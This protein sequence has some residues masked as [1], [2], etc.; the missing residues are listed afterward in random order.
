MI[1]RLKV[2]FAYQRGFQV[3]DGSHVLETFDT[4]DEA[5]RY[6]DARDARV[7][8]QWA[9][10]VIGGQTMPCDFAASFGDDH[11]VGR[12]M[13]N[14]HGPGAGTWFWSMYSHDRGRVGGEH[15]I[16]ATKDQAVIGVERAYTRFIAAGAVA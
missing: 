12:I 9:R 7:W 14:V 11:S 10:M 15:G 2:R 16:V 4:R 6:V 5:F 1:E 13:K 8:L 3:V